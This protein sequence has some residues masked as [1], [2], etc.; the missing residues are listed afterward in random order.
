MG[1]FHLTIVELVF[2]GLIATVVF[3][4]I[5]TLIHELGHAF[6]ALRVTSQPVRVEVGRE[7]LRFTLIVERLTV[8]WSPIPKKTNPR[9]VCYWQSQ[10]ASPRQEMWVTL[11]GPIATALLIVPYGLAA[12]LTRNAAAWIQAVFVL[13]SLYCL[14]NVATNLDTR[15]TALLGKA[16]PNPERLDGSKALS[17]YRRS[18]DRAGASKTGPNEW[19]SWRDRSQ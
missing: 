6:G 12:Y 4:P 11:A 13:S 15:K 9:G 7:A 17:A 18:R 1:P 5:S 19:S 3:E 16:P 8:M 2:A 10:T 14:I